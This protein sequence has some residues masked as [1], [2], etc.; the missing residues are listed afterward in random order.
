VSAVFFVAEI[1][2]DILNIDLET[3]YRASRM[4]LPKSN[5]L[6]LMVFADWLEFRHVTLISAAYNLSR[7]MHTMHEPVA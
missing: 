3:L 6:F 5:S 1:D 2:T 4:F 7:T